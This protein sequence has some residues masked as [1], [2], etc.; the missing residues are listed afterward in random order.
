[1]FLLGIDGATWDKID[2]LIQQK[3]LPHFE[4]LRKD[5]ATARLKTIVPTASPTIWTTIATGHLP[6]DHGIQD[7][8]VRR[9]RFLPSYALVLENRPLRTLFSFLDLYTVVPVTSN[10]RRTK[11]I[12]NLA[13]EMNIPIGSVGWWA[14]YPAEIVK[15]W[16][17]SDATSHAWVRR[18]MAKHEQL[19]TRAMANTFPEELAAELAPLHRNVESITKEELGRFMQLDDTAWSDFHAAADVDKES[20]LS[21]WHSAF[22]RDEFFVASALEIEKRY[23]PEILFC[24]TRFTDDIAHFFWEY[25]EAEARELGRD[26]KRIA[27]YKD[28]VDRSYEWA[29]AIV[30]KFMERLGPGDTLV[31]CSDHGWER[32]GRGMYHHNNGPDGI[33]AF[34]GSSA[35]PGHAIGGT[36]HILDVAPTLLWLAGIPKGADM[37]GTALRDAFVSPPEEKTI[38]TWE[39]S[40]YRTGAAI[41]MLDAAG[42]VHELEQLGYVGGKK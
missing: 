18:L 41:E 26:P 10:F 2:P 25:S 35:K 37:A 3:R 4:T 40:S 34:Y 8:V 42:R 23:K 30:G 39:T 21:I 17:V 14:S 33:I 13:T 1:V 38:P 11:A 12:W 20:P 36:P 32:A 9:T 27:R 5:G 22:L 31:V 29:D 16:I 28:T 6:S 24:Y 15:G 19:E 7:F